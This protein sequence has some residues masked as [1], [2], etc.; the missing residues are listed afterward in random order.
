MPPRPIEFWFDFSSSY[1]YF[2]AHQLDAVGAR[3]GR[4]V[5]W[6][7]FMLGTAFR[8]TGMRGWSSTPLRRDYALRDW[9]RIAGEL[10][11][12][13]ALPP[14]H[15]TVSLPAMRVFYWLEAHH[16]DRAVPFARAV[17]SAYYQAQLDSGDLG[18]VAALAEELGLDR[19]AV[20]AGAG[21][22]AIKDLARRQSETAVARG[23]FG[24]PFFLVDDEPFWGWDRLPMMERWLS[25]RRSGAAVEA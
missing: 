2:A 20:V 15:P 16:A 4:P 24:S 3:V 13:F 10:R 1:A 9:R 25:A 22:P 5:L 11:L 14:N 19:A 6:R 18:A 23:V 12:P 8:V 7:P 17:F 21:D